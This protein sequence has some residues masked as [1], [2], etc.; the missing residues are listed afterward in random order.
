[1]SRSQKS[2]WHRQT[3]ALRFETCE[4]RV[5][6]TARSDAARW[7]VD[8]LTGDSTILHQPRPQIDLLPASLANAH[9]QTGMDIVRQRFGLSGA[10][11]T[12]AIIDSGVAFDHAALGS[13]FGEGYRVVG[14]WDFT[15]GSSLEG[16]WNPYDDGPHGSH[17]THVAGI[18]GSDDP[19][20]LG[21]A[22]KADLVALRVF[23]DDGA[24][25]FSWVEQALTWVYD[26]RN[27]FRNPITA[28]NLSLG[29]GWNS[30]QPPNWAMLE[31]ELQ[32]LDQV[33]IFISVAAGNDFESYNSPGLDYPAASPYAVAAMSTESSG[34]LSYFS[35]RHDRAI[36]A[37]GQGIRST[38]P[39]YVGN[40]NGEADDFATYSGTS[41]AAPYLAGAS[42]IV[43]QALE[44]VGRTNIDQD[45]IYDV[46]RETADTISDS[47]TEADYKRL[48]LER[49]IDSILGDDH[50]G[51]STSSAVKL[52]EFGLR[53]TA[54]GSINYEGDRDYFR[55]TAA[56]SGTV[57]LC[58]EGG[59][60]SQF[61]LRRYYADGTSRYVN[62][63]TLQME[64]EAGRRYYISIRD[65]AGTGDYRASFRVTPRFEDL[66]DVGERTL[67]HQRVSGERW[68][69]FN[70]RED[71]AVRAEGW[72]EQN[73]SDVRLELY[74]QNLYRICTDDGRYKDNVTD[75]AT[76]GETFFVRVAGNNSDVKL[77]LRS[78]AIETELPPAV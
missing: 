9:E 56:R 28:V 33:G 10:G 6:M 39:D 74:D 35:Q 51:Q 49:A 15:E 45:M 24:G 26:H 76:D 64:V 18:V 65:R 66:G 21:V 16:E 69:C 55:F 5:M 62:S 34:Y 43:R 22:P 42:V 1:M 25:W 57:E 20:N 32:L 7:A 23:D 11:Q 12:V 78:V 40:G 50:E 73:T 38:V 19:D 44:M 30:D 61:Q 60:T 59:E 72:I 37:P 29:V 58:V 53:K 63:D 71:G 2:Q 68:Y 75:A 14:G 3:R 54:W 48:N 4:P 8:Y 36:A 41:M 31:D 17:G 27:D 47:V 67:R 52:G 77:R 46:I 13:G 70:S